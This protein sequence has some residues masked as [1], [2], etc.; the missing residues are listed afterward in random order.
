MSW[1]L[2]CR[3][4]TETHKK[5]KKNKQTNKRNNTENTT[6]QHTVCSAA[7]KYEN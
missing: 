4:N 1:A 6:N 2:Y 7:E 3:K 5:T